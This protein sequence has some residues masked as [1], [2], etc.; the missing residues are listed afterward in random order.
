MA[1]IINKDICV[2]GFKIRYYKIDI[3]LNLLLRYHNFLF[4]V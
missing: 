1:V 4:G 3:D 2:N